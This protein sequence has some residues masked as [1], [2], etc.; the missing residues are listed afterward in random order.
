MASRLIV[1]ILE[2]IGSMPIATQIITP[3]ARNLY[4]LFLQSL[5]FSSAR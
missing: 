4:C 3:L 5:G 1:I 2:A